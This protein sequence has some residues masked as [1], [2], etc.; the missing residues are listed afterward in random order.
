MPSSWRGLPIAVLSHF[1]ELQR[2][3]RRFQQ[4]RRP[5]IPAEAAREALLTVGDS[6]FASEN[7]DSARSDSGQEFRR[8]LRA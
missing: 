8:R 2:M 6:A 1:Q 7:E 4:F 3:Q 5:I